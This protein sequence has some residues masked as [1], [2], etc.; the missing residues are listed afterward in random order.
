MRYKA[1][2]L[3]IAAAWVNRGGKALPAGAAPPSF[4]VADLRELMAEVG[5]G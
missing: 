1:L 5:G 2:L 4:T 3:G